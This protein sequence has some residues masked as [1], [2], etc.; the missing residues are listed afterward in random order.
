[1]HIVGAG[2]G[3][4]GLVTV[5]ALELVGQ[6]DVLVYDRLIPPGLVEAAPSGCERVDAGKLPDRH[7]LAQ[8]QINALLVDRARAGGRVVR[9]KGG[10]PFVL[11][12]GG[13]EAEACAEAGVPFE[14]VPGVS[15]AVAVPA[16]AGIPV[17]HRDLSST[18]AVVTGHE[19]PNGE[20]ASTR[21]AALARVGTV[22]VLMGMGRLAAIADRLTEAGRHP[23]TP[24]AVVE[25][26]TT[27]A[28]RVVRATLATIAE[29]A[30]RAGVRAP[31][32]IVIGEVVA[33]GD[34]LAWY[35][36]RPLFGQTV[37][38]PRT[39]EQASSFSALLR[40]RGAE[41]LEAPT[42]EVRPPETTA[43]LDRAVGL[44]AAG[45]YDWVVL[46][47]A[48]GV[49]ALR[50]RVEAAGLDARALGR[51]RVAAVGP[52]TE[53]QLR[54]WG[55]AA[56]LVPD[57]ATTA[58][59]GEAFPDLPGRVL[60]PR[61]DLANPELSRAVAAKGGDPDDVVAYRTV[62]LEEMDPAARKR[63]DGGEVD[64]VAFTA[65]S[66]VT[67]FVRAYGGP[68]PDGVRVAVIGPVTAGAARAARMQ[69]A[70]EAREHTIPGLVAAIEQAVAAPRPQP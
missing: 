41:P 28:Q 27:P 69:V 33:M 53:A 68:P 31:A 21:W 30:V 9:L 38:V 37:L 15:S 23:D 29:E 14:V 50:D 13:E 32:V 47:S 60:L 45:A 22:C 35:E 39:R 8:A 61:A 40:E 5:R 24:A 65:A 54:A 59:L 25:Q 18:F 16:Y 17:T 44:L 64:W 20:P 57:V 67:G 43:E 46:T 62:P 26:G 4:P 52:A 7:P 49:A 42:I 48:N 63:L 58:A 66:T 6:A 70:A 56:D 10:D 2:P 36:N 55:I 1:M 11:G 51:A 34:R 12:R 19:D 3:D